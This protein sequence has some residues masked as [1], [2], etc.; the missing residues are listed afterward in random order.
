MAVVTDEG[1]SRTYS[2][3]MEVTENVLERARS[4]RGVSTARGG[5]SAY[6][7]YSAFIFKGEA[8]EWEEVEPCV[9]KALRVD[10]AK[11]KRK[12]SSKTVVGSEKI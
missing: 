9:L 5:E 3:R 4:C 1:K 11:V 7:K 10:P 12:A 6:A 2:L 8:F